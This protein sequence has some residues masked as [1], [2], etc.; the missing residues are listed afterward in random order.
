MHEG[1]NSAPQ[2][3]P[4]GSRAWN[5]YLHACMRTSSDSITFYNAH[6]PSSKLK[7]QT[8]HSRPEQWPCRGKKRCSCHSHPAVHRLRGECCGKH[9]L[10]VRGN[11][12]QGL[13][14][15]KKHWPILHSHVGS[16]TQCNCS[17]D[18]QAFQQFFINYKIRDRWGYL[19]IYIYIWGG[20]GNLL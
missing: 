20:L 8:Y 15:P 12:L 18:R 9:H 7:K 13:P 4:R 5:A 2:R 19:Y 1:L 10:A 17:R 11:Q 14:R 3:S 6:S 16:H